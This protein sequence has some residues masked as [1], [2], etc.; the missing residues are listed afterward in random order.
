MEMASIYFVG[1]YSPIMCG[2]ADY[3]SY[4]TRK[5]PSR[6]WG[7]LSFDLEK[8]GA[9]LSGND[10]AHTNQVWYGIPG[11]HDFSATV[12]RDGLKRLGMEDGNTLLWFQHEN[13]IWPDSQK[14]V[15]MLENLDIPKVVTFHTLHFQSPD[16]P[17]GLGRNQRDLLQSLLP[18][19]DAITV[20]SDGVYYAV[21]TAFPEYSDKVYVLKH[22]VHSHPEVSRVSRKE[23][24]EKLNDFLL[25]ETDLAQAVKE[26][27][28]KQRIFLN[29]GNVVIG[30]TGFLDP[31]KRT[32]LLYVVRDS[33]RQMI[34]DREIVAVRIGKSKDSV[35][36]TYTT[37]LVQ[38]QDCMSESIFD[39][40]LPESM[41]R[42]AQRAFDINFYWPMECTQSG[43]LAHALGAGAIVAGRDL[44]GVGE[45]LKE[46][47]GLVGTDLVDLLLQMRDLIL[48]PEA[49]KEM[50]ER[51]LKY[52]AKFSWSK[53][54]WRH[55][56][57]AERILHPLYPQP[58]SQFPSS[59][60]VST[61]IV[62]D[63]LN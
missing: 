45:T 30:Q 14:F 24:R 37:R 53:Q 9:P 54:A 29:P 13:G 36:R 4:L 10:G 60:E 50:E 33:L 15:A 26:S 51:A 56:E 38:E 63:R 41:L 22:G 47:G 20:F 16:T 49:S 35:Q 55:Y 28:H 46:A 32:D 6:R 23:A 2:I 52:S 59:N 40:W 12:I 27:L 34:R 17:S 21:A 31:N 43:V 18:H 42:V 1:T 62:A 44:E 39:V 61:I 25:Y 8:Y 5:S 7:V 11:R 19:V 57:L 48:S 3:T 58:L